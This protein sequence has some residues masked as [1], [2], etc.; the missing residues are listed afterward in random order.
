MAQMMKRRRILQ[1]AAGLPAAIALRAQNPYAAA[2]S[3]KPDELPKL[4]AIPPDGVADAQRK[5]CTGIQLAAL[6]R[7]CDMV[8][9]RI[10]ETPGAA[11]AQAAEFLDFLLSES[12]ADRQTLYRTGLDAL[13]TQARAKQGKSF[14]EVDAATAAEILAPLGKPWTYKDPAEPLTKF[15]R[16]AKADILTATVNSREWIQV[17]SQRNRNAAGTSIFWTEIA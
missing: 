7:L 2:T 1:V 10:G 6:K 16:T 4:E 15:L 12:P 13:N 14:A 8:L 5:F 3:G 11:E 9:P 17:V